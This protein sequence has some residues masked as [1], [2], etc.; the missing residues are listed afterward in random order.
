MLIFRSNITTR[1]SRDKLGFLLVTPSMPEHKGA[2]VLLSLPAGR[3]QAMKTG[4][5][6]LQS[7][8]NSPTGV[9]GRGTL[10]VGWLHLPVPIPVS[11]LNKGAALGR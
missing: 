10:Q 7:L 11:S 3:F 5:G 2:A 1:A 4:F 9:T 8:G 6:K